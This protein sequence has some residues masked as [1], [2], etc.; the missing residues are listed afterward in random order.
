MMST[1]CSTPAVMVVHVEDEI[2]VVPRGLIF[3]NYVSCKNARA[4]R[5]GQNLGFD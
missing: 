2:S 1:G 3:I 5:Q 4:M